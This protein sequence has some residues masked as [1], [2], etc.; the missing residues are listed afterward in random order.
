MKK[1]LCVAALGVLVL[2]VYKCVTDC[3]CKTKPHYIFVKD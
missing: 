3:P 1:L 2:F